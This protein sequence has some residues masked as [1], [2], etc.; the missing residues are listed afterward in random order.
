MEQSIRKSIS[1]SE[2]EI[3]V[4]RRE[5]LNRVSRG[6]LSV[7]KE[8]QDLLDKYSSLGSSY[9]KTWDKLRWGD[10]KVDLLRSR[11]ISNISLLTAFNTS[12]VN[13]SQAKI[14]ARL[15]QVL[16]E[17]QEG[18]RQSSVI[19]QLSR[20]IDHLI[21]PSDGVWRQVARELG[22]DAS[23][24]A[25]ANRALIVPRVQ[26]ALYEEPIAKRIDVVSATYGTT[27]VT[28]H[29]RQ[30]F[31]QLSLRGSSGHTFLP[32]NVFFGF[33]PI[34][35]S[36]KAF[37]LLWRIPIPNASGSNPLERP[38][39]SAVQK[40]RVLEGDPVVLTLDGGLS[41]ATAVSSSE[42]VLILDASYFMLDVTALVKRALARARPGFPVAIA[43]TNA[44]FGTDPAP[45][46]VKQLSITYAYPHSSF[47]PGLT[48]HCIT[49][50]VTEGEAIVIPPRLTIH[51]AY[52]A[53]LDIT[54]AMRTRIAADQ[55]L[56]ISVDSH[57]I[58]G[59]AD[60]WWNVSKTISIMY[61]YGQGPL[62]LLVT[63]DGAGMQSITPTG[64]PRTS[65]FNPQSGQQQD[66]G[67][68]QVLAVVWG[69][70]ARRLTQLQYQW[71]SE[72]RW[73]SCSNDWF[74]FDGYGGWHKTCQVFCRTGEDGKIMCRAAREG[75]Q[76]IL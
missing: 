76:W 41:R 71:I 5:E 22:T 38:A 3:A 39:F 26:E 6:S 20:G 60:P 75:Q 68:F 57:L 14:L 36:K 37:I 42:S 46:H 35:D 56:H 11:I 70:S 74:G 7:L 73:F 29:V 10:E 28:N 24:D 18:K 25:Y 62:Q 53:D 66:Q 50:V 13:A 52:W 30:F 34:P 33:D 32:D 51:V 17:I 54:T 47:I 23:L 12:L 1:E 69:V 45:N 16:A 43:A 59:V 65:Q 63:H 40:T 58:P 64:P 44:M 19:P 27:D 31:H 4:K 55:S 8:L 48:E 9:R 72:R 67:G 49:R 61:Q 15:D 21:G 2:T